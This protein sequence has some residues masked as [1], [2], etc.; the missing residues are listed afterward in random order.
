[1]KKPWNIINSPVY[2]LATYDDDKVNMNICTYVSAVSMKPKQ[3]VVGVYQNTKSLDNISAS[4]K[5]V[6]QLLHTSHVRLVNSLGK[7]SGLQFDKNRYL[8]KHNLLT[9]W[10]GYEVL[11]N[12]AA[13]LLLEKKWSK[14]TGDH[15]LVLFDVV[16]SKTFNAEI[17]T[18]DDLR[19]NKLI[20][21]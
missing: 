9:D 8:I 19:K 16:G 13:L 2:S 10:N 18:L 12:T 7:K 20:R 17:L 14:V 3:Y 1:M 6:L 11:A 5:A 15:T 4:S 21:I